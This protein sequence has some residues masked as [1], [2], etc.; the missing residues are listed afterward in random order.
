[1]SLC[2]LCFHPLELYPNSVA[3]IGAESPHVFLLLS[4]D[5]LLALSCGL[6][7]CVGGIPRRRGLYTKI[8]ITLYSTLKKPLPYKKELFCAALEGEGRGEGVAALCTEFVPLTFGATDSN[9]VH[10]EFSQV[11]LRLTGIEAFFPSNLAPWS[12]TPTGADCCGCGG[13]AWGGA[14]G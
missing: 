8:T 10:C 3:S 9:Y 14:A 13:V 2:V 11:T 4:H 12:N 1:M 5:H 6:L 7:C